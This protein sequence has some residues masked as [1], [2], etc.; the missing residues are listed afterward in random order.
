MKPGNNVATI[1][2]KARV[3]EYMF[4]AL[5]TYLIA[6]ENGTR[7]K[8]KLENQLFHS[9]K[10]PNE[11][12]IDVERTIIFFLVNRTV[13]ECYVILQIINIGSE[14]KKDLSSFLN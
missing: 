4:Y 1:R 8:K 5:P 14:I 11:K 10:A 6:H 9:L 2:E 13:C 12:I 3:A 7:K